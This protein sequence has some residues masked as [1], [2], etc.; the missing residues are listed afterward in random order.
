MLLKVDS[1]LTTSPHILLGELAS[2]QTELAAIQKRCVPAA[3]SLDAAE[4]SAA[5]SSPAWIAMRGI[6]TMDV[7]DGKPIAWLTMEERD[8]F[9]A[10]YRDGRAKTVHYGPTG[11]VGLAQVKLVK[12]Q[13]DGG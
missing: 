8:A 3:L 4:Q 2:I 12:P 11:L 9:E 10:M 5:S 1:L 6:E 13:K 7:L